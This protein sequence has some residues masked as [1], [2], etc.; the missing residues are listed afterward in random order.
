VRKK[1]NFET[2]PLKSGRRQL[3]YGPPSRKAPKIQS[4]WQKAFKEYGVT[5]NK[6]EKRQFLTDLDF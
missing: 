6:K 5:K 1:W 2:P 3:N 4:P